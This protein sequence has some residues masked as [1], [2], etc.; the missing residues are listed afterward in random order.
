VFVTAQHF[1]FLFGRGCGVLNDRKVA[2]IYGCTGVRIPKK[3]VSSNEI[4]ELHETN[5]WIPDVK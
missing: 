2:A 5:A 3:L 4:Q 1:I